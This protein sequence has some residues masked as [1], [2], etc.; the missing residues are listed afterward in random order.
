MQVTGVLMMHR[1][2][3]PDGLGQIVREVSSLNLAPAYDFVYQ[4]ENDIPVKYW[5]DVPST[6]KPGYLK[7]MRE[8]RIA[9]TKEGY[10]DKTMMQ[11]L[12]R[13]R[14]KFEPTNYE[15]SM[16]EE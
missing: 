14:C 16:N 12:K 3:F 7:M 5:M 15:C 6:D 1:G 8:A 11:F 13:V 9:M 2:K 4:T 10:Y